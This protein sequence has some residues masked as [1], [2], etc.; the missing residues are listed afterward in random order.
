MLCSIVLSMLSVFPNRVLLLLGTP[1]PFKQE[2]R[3]CSDLA[4][5]F[6]IDERNTMCRSNTDYSL[7]SAP[8]AAHPPSSSLALVLRTAQQS[9]ELV[10]QQWVFYDQI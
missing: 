2:S 8:W 1:H 9:Q 6:H 3:S 4:L 10:F 7:S 5:A